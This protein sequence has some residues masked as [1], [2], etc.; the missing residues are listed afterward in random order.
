MQRAA[1]ARRFALSVFVLLVLPQKGKPDESVNLLLDGGGERVDVAMLTRH[2]IRP[3]N[4][5]RL[6]IDNQ[7]AAPARLLLCNFERAGG[8]PPRL[9]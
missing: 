1:A 7:N 9:E 8:S 2:G 5:V 4:G 6:W 3:A